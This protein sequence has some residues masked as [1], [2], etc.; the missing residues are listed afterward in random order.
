MTRESKSI[1]NKGVTI[2]DIAYRCGLL[3]I[4]TVSKALAV[5]GDTW[6]GTAGP[7]G[8]SPRLAA[9]PRIP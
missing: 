5:C 7:S 6:R 1:A 9:R 8:G 3:G 2:R 4:A